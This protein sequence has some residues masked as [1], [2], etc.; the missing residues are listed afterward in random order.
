MNATKNNPI[1]GETITRYLLGELSIDEQEPI[2][3]GFADE[4]FYERVLSVEEDLIDAYVQGKLPQ[5]RRKSFE[6]RFL[7]TPDQRERVAMARG[8]FEA[9][10]EL[11]Q[12]KAAQT[13]AAREQITGSAPAEESPSFRQRLRAFFSDLNPAAGWAMAAASLLLFLGAAYLFIQGR[14]AQSQIAR[15]Q[16]DNQALQARNAEQKSLFE[17]EIEGAREQMK[18]KDAALTESGAQ[19]EKLRKQL[20]TIQS[21]KGLSYLPSS[22]FKTAQFEASL[23]FPKGSEDK[24]IELNKTLL[25]GRGANLAWLELTFPGELADHYQAALFRGAND[26]GEP[27]VTLN[28]LKARS[29]NGINTLVISFPATQLP[30][31]KYT[32]RLAEVKDSASRKIGKWSFNIGYK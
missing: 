31:G 4:E 29:A 8:M 12:E 16:N 15:L 30:A 5:A 9:I 19:N 17:R 11:Q 24:P 27:I 26:T 32:V 7:N 10:T 13:A 6:R 22:G 25:L 18:Q 3:L 20:E 23:P 21:G 28:Q 2:D 1:N 14:Q